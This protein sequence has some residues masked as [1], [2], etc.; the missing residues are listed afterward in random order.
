MFFFFGGKGAVCCFNRAG[1][2]ASS[3]PRNTWA[4][5]VSIRPATVRDTYIRCSSSVAEPLSM[6]AFCSRGGK[7]IHINMGVDSFSEKVSVVISF[8]WYIY[9]YIYHT[10]LK[11]FSNT[12]QLIWVTNDGH[13]F[14]EKIYFFLIYKRS[15]SNH[16]RTFNC[17]LPHTLH[18]HQVLKSNKNH[19]VSGQ[20]VKT[21]IKI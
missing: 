20:T 6:D 1:Q 5:Y 11:N 14:G 10:F 16:R 15:F 3:D 9:I 4:A 2:L 13:Y 8:N 21:K 18:L 19:S 7:N 17:K 12:K